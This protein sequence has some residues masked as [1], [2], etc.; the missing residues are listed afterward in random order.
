MTG[1]GTTNIP[2]TLSKVSLTSFIRMRAMMI[3]L[4]IVQFIIVMI[5]LVREKYRLKV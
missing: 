4:M 2:T 1:L 5:G 3:V